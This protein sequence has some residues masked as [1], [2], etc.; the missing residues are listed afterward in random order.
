MLRDVAHASISFRCDVERI[1]GSYVLL[2]MLV[3][4]D[5]EA[6]DRFHHVQIHTRAL[7]V[8]SETHETNEVESNRVKDLPAMRMGTISTARFQ[9]HCDPIPPMSE[10]IEDPPDPE[11]APSPCLCLT[12]STLSLGGRAGFPRGLPAHGSGGRGHPDVPHPPP[13]PWQVGRGVDPT[14]AIRFLS[15]WTSQKGSSVLHPP[16]GRSPR[17]S[18]SSRPPRRG[19]TL[20][21]FTHGGSE[22]GGKVHTRHTSTMATSK[23]FLTCVT[24]LLIGVCHVHAG[25]QPDFF[26]AD[27]G[28]TVL[29]PNAEVGDFG[30]VNGV[31]YTKRTKQQIDGTNA[32]TTCTSGI[33]D[34]SELFAEQASFDQ[35][36]GSWDTSQVTNMQG[37]FYF[38][39]SFNQDIGH[40]DTSRVTDMQIMFQS[41]SSFDQDIGNWDTSQVTNMQSFF[42]SASSFDQD[43]G[44]WDTSQVTN[45]QGMFRSASNF[46]QDIGNWITSQV[47]NMQRMF[48]SAGSFDQAIGDWDTSQVT[49]MRFLFVSAGNFN[50]DIGN[51]TTSKVTNMQGMF[52]SASSFNQDLSGWCVGSVSES[53]DFDSFA[54]A[55]TEPRPPTFGSIDNCK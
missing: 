10:G 30:K 26:L 46:N 40:W 38:A 2:S 52:Q 32:A 35:N 36:I 14:V 37:M 51:W 39:S 34:M 24:L 4:R 21:S 7:D 11:D 22:R 43:I 25:D 54:T 12:P 28:V 55:W 53:S 29:C 23:H 3:A 18:R 6:Q 19:V 1:R 20:R 13:T 44:R 16:V 50:Q 48:Q 42:Y 31:T 45:M 49:D 8:A 33:T 5:V 17:R 41:A 47:T 15:S 9:R 27:N